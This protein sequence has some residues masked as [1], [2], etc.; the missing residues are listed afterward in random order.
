MGIFPARFS[1]LEHGWAWPLSETSASNP[2]WWLMLYEN[3]EYVADLRFALEV[4]DEYAHLG[5]DSEHATQLRDLM[6]EQIEK[7]ET[8][9]SQ[10]HLAL[11][12]AADEEASE[13]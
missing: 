10:L 5:L 9:L 8:A 12:G 6:L 13:D 1:V 7:A 11:V 3:P 2:V 4:M